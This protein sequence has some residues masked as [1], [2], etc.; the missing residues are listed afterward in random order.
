MRVGHFEPVG[1]ERGDFSMSDRVKA[2]I[3]ILGAVIAVL[4]L[5]FNWYLFGYQKDKNTLSIINGRSILVHDYNRD[6]VRN[7][8]SYVKDYPTGPGGNDIIA[9]KFVDMQS[10]NM[11]IVF[12]VYRQLRVCI[13]SDQC[14]ISVMK[15]S[16]SLCLDMALDICVLDT[17][18]KD[19]KSINFGRYDVLNSARDHADSIV[20]LVGKKK[21]EVCKAEISKQGRC[22]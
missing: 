5:G 4:S 15:N 9:Q 16:G 3:A 12:D 13:E 18:E 20:N 1:F 22:G 21:V 10:K 19:L 6:I 2:A 7:L 8:K 17:M 14:S 11:S